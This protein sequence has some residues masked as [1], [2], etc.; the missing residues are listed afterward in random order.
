MGGRSVS[1]R[2]D[3]IDFRIGTLQ[4]QAVQIHYG[5]NIV[6]IGIVHVLNQHAVNCGKCAIAETRYILD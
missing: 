2:I 5:L 3:S 4:N 6:N 1:S